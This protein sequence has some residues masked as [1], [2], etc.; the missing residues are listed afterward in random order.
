[1]SVPDKLASLPG[2]WLGVNRLWQM[3]NE[4]AVVSE[5]EADVA[6]V[7]QS[8]FLSIQ[9]TWVYA[10]VIQEGLLLIGCEPESSAASAAWVDA[11]HN[12]D[13]MMNCRGTLRPDGSILVMGTYPAPGGEDWGWWIVLEAVDENRF[14]IIMS[15]VPPGGE[16]VL[17]VEMSFERLE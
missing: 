16:P 14:K 15:N 13:R 6:L 7:A 1:M 5:A 17:A 11:W 3:P 9:Y 8:K 12:G 2:G 10:D 4:P